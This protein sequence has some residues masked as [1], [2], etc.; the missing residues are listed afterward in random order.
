MV[1]SDL[2]SAQDALN[3]Q[4]FVD[5]AIL[6]FHKPPPTSQ[7][8]VPRNS[9]HDAPTVLSPVMLAD[10]VKSTGMGATLAT[11]AASPIGLLQG[12]TASSRSSLQSQAKRERRDS[13]ATAT[14][15]EP[16]NHLA[17]NDD[18]GLSD[19]KDKRRNNVATQ[20][21]VAPK[22]LR[23]ASPEKRV[24][25]NLASKKGR[26][27]GKSK[28]NKEDVSQMGPGATDRRALNDA[29]STQE[30]M[31]LT[32]TTGTGWRKSP[33]VEDSSTLQVSGRSRVRASTKQTKV[34][35]RKA[36]MEERNGWATEDATDIQE[37]GEF[38]F[39]SN[40]SKF[41]KRR[42][43]A[44]IRNEDLTADEDRLVSFN[45]RVPKLGTNEGKN[46]HHTENVLE[47]PTRNIWKS[48]AG[49]TE[50]D[51]IS[52]DHVSSGRNS[53][54]GMNKSATLRATSRKTSTMLGQ[55]LTPGHLSRRQSS[56]TESPRPSKTL[57]SN[58][59]RNGS[60]SSSRAS[61]RVMSTNRPC[62]CVSPLQMLEIEQLAVS[63][64]GLTEDMITENAGRGIAEAV[65]S[66]PPN[67]STT[68]N[69]WVLVG[70]HKSGSRAIAAAR[71]LKNRGVLVTL[72]LLGLEREE[73][74]M[75]SLKRQLN[76]YRKINGMVSSWEELLASMSTSTSLPELV[77]DALLGMHI[78]FEDLRT[79]DQATVFEMM[80]WT[81][82][83]GVEVISV[84][85]PSG[86]VGSTGESPTVGDL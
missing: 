79:D 18:A 48:E 28:A 72:C 13:A 66:Q 11:Q 23:S 39:E 67:I 32:G 70:N 27:G 17:V 16:F 63:E 42:V 43:F 81:N 37:L 9:T 82:R 19:G 29:Q 1:D 51:E 26:R 41:D 57:S 30:Q 21:W 6:S 71:H 60:I 85:M 24:T 62:A 75:E 12:M 49:E 25:G 8:L 69:V 34:K 53:H 20:H 3:S 10:T 78:S 68:S 22:Q 77:V 80:S 47:V 5:P 45:R 50:E 38:D 35:A 61:L 14:L 15:T 36:Y 54:R 84:D 58:S 52:D 73:E 31:A 83:S 74:L 4:S 56:R 33:L 55:A 2:T 59:P 64:L 40:L 86:L 46:L 76:I 65:L 44:E 7:R